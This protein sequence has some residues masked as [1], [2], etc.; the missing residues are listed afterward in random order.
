M[1]DSYIQTMCF[2]LQHSTKLIFKYSFCF[3]FREDLDMWALTGQYHTQWSL[4]RWTRWDLHTYRVHNTPGPNT[5][6]SVV[7]GGDSRFDYFLVSLLCKFIIWF[8]YSLLF[9]RCF[10]FCIPV[11]FFTLLY[12]YNDKEHSNNKSYTSYHVGHIHFSLSP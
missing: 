11:F 8:V 9:S 1:S 2:C 7:G 6:D 12:Y 5:N 3:F 4:L 10:S